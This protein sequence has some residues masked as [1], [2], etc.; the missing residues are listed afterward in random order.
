VKNVDTKKYNQQT[1]ETSHKPLLE[2]YLIRDMLTYNRD[3]FN[4][5]ASKTRF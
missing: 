1:P 5:D 4:L 2:L 3:G